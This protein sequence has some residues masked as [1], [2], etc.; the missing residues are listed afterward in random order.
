MS[1]LVNVTELQR[2][3]MRE[4]FLLLPHAHT[5]DVVVRV[6]GQD[7]HFEADWLFELLLLWQYV[8]LVEKEDK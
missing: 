3:A 7:R 2:Q 8:E 5:I 4:L 6:N 1:P